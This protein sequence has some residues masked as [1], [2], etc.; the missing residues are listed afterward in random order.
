MHVPFC[1]GWFV[2]RGAFLGPWFLEPGGHTWLVLDTVLGPVHSPT[3]LRFPTLPHEYS[4]CYFLL[5]AFCFVL[6]HDV[7][8][9]QLSDWR[10]DTDWRLSEGRMVWDLLQAQESSHSESLMWGKQTGTSPMG[11]MK[12]RA[13]F[14]FWPRPCDLFYSLVPHPTKT[15]HNSDLGVFKVI[16]WK[17]FIVFTKNHTSITTL[18]SSNI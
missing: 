10:G 18:C 14:K 16:I 2:H 13:L 3:Q 12:D 6:F 7:F 11:P 4:M 15:R 1:S 9:I 17:L 5:C 8:R